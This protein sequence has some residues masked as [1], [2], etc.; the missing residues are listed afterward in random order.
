MKIPQLL[1][2][3]L[4]K[5]RKMSLPGLGIFTL[6]KSVVLPEENDRVLL[7]MPNAVQFQNANIAAADKELI[8]YITEH[9][10]KIRPLAISDLDS[11]LNL[12]TEMLNIGKPFH[13]EGIG[14]ITK[15]RTGK[16]DFTPG[17][18][19]LVRENDPTSDHGKR[20]PHTKDKPQ[21]NT[22]STGQNRTLLKLLVFVGALAV[23]GF[24]GWLMYKK[25]SPAASEKMTDAG[26]AVQAPVPAATDSLTDSTTRHDSAKP[27]SKDTIHPPAVSGQSTANYKFVILT[28]F[29]K[30]HAIRR[31]NQLLSFDLKPHLY[32]KDSTLFKIYFQFPAMARDTVHI[33]DSLRREYGHNVII[34]Q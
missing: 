19:S 11:Y 20:K 18:Y 26:S 22:P 8:S 1:V 13:L 31:Y 5:Y 16:F 30:P 34:E 29:N 33:K 6:D 32:Q 15:N 21:L 28:T 23:V 4:Y 3:Y 24:G 9:T 10:G 25:N 14:I 17:E 12:G 7:S 27:V 2:Q